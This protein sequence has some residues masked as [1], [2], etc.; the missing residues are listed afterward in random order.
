MFQVWKIAQ[1]YFEQFSKVKKIFSLLTSPRVWRVE[2][3]C[4][5]KRGGGTRNPG[6]NG[7]GGRGGW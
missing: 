3:H 4:C 2:E 5:V 1:K 6:G 7:V